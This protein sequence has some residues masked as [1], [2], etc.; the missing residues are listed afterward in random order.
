MSYTAS[1]VL[2][3][4]VLVRQAPAIF[5]NEQGYKLDSCSD[6]AAEEAL[7]C[8]V[9]LTQA[10]PHPEFSGPTGPLTLPCK[11]SPL[12]VLL[13]AGTPLGHIGP[14]LSPSLLVR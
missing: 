11:L 6:A 5:S 2:W 7:K 14:K 12:S 3:L 9:I 8:F 10:D 1:Y 4:G 13:L